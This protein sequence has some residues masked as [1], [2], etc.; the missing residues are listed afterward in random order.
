MTI[1][2]KNVRVVMCTLAL[3]VLTHA[4]ARAQN[5][6]APS[7]PTPSATPK[8]TPSATPKAT[9]SA[10][11]TPKSTPA[12]SASPTPSF[13]TPYADASIRRLSLVTEQGSFKNTFN[14]FRDAYDASRGN[15]YNYTLRKGSEIIV[16]NARCDGDPGL[17]QFSVYSLSNDIRLLVESYINYYVANPTRQSTAADK[18]RERALI[19]AIMKSLT[20]VFPRKDDCDAIPVALSLPETITR[21]R[22]DDPKMIEVVPLTM[23]N[24]WLRLEVDDAQSPLLGSKINDA[25]IYDDFM[26]KAR[27]TTGRR[28]F[29]REFWNRYAYNRYAS[30]QDAG[31]AAREVFGTKAIIFNGTNFSI[32]RLNFDAD[33]KLDDTQYDVYKTTPIRKGW[34]IV[35]L[36]LVKKYIQIY[37]PKAKKTT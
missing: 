10:S 12:P 6:V 17:A 37:E 30:A 3:S 1:I 14:S 7:T 32:Y 16:L 20:T 11:P 33:Y 19:D 21:V 25:F 36:V 28:T 4:A 34:K 23:P 27:G 35:G 15:S 8:V 2:L 24:N 13:L 29:S 9:P 5:T 31:D 18:K 22:V 26:S